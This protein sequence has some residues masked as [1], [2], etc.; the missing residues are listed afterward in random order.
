MHDRWPLSLTPFN[1][2]LSHGMLHQHTSPIRAGTFVYVVPSISLN[3]W[4]IALSMAGSL[5]LLLFHLFYLTV[6]GLSGGMWD[7]VP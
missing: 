7:L 5:L 3:N 1:A 2:S 6:L 4:Y